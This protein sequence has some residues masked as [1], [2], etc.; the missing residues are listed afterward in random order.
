[1]PTRAS[2]PEAWF[3]KAEHDRATIRAVVAGD[4]PLWDIATF[5]AQQAAE[6]YLKGFIV[7]RSG[8]VPK[9]HDLTTLLTLCCEYDSTFIALEEGSRTLT[10]L[11]WVSR[12]PESNDDTSE[13]E[14]R[15][16]IELADEV[17]S[18][19]RERVPKRESP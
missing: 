13:A 17:C 16:A 19:V 3:Q 7:A 12:Y 10:R 14:G 6:K 11:G 4:P 15:R 8:T 5:H 1:M 9:I 2:Q 18:A